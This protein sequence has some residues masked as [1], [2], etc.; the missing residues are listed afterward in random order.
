MSKNKYR[1][2][3]NPIET[4]VGEGE[5]VIHE[6]KPLT[7]TITYVK[8]IQPALISFEYLDNIKNDK[9]IITLVD[10]FIIVQSVTKNVEHLIP[11]SNVSS[12]TIQ[13]E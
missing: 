10:N 3:K 8:F 9:F 2:N 5:R 1:E 12:I 4:S 13:Y 7:K 11:L 6:V